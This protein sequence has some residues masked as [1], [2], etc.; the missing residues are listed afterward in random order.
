MR[1]KIFCENER[2]CTITGKITNSQ[3]LT[4]VL[5]F[6]IIFGVGIHNSFA[7][8][9]ERWVVGNVVDIDERPTAKSAKTNAKNG[10]DYKL[11]NECARGGGLLTKDVNYVV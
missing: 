11:H 4:V 3:L 7:A 2:S 5:F 8:E 1:K 9:Y 10:A 6:S